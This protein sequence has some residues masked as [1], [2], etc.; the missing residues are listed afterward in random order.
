METV[1]LNQRPVPLKGA[2]T[3]CV[4]RHIFDYIIAA[5]LLIQCN[6]VWMTIASVRQQMSTA[7]PI[8]LF[9]C[10]VGRMALSMRRFSLAELKRDAILLGALCAYLAILYA[11]I[12]TNKNV[13]LSFACMFLLLL[14]YCL[15]C[16]RDGVSQILLK[17]RTLVCAVAAI[18]IVMWLLCSVFRLIPPSGV[19]M[20]SWND[21]SNSDTPIVSWFGLYFEAQSG[22]NTSIFTEGPMAALQYSLALLIETF[23]AKK[24]HPVLSGILVAA[25]CTTMT[26]TG[27]LV[28]LLVALTY[29]LRWLY[30]KGWLQKKA[31]KITIATVGSIG[32]V[33]VIVILIWKIDTLSGSIRFDD[34]R[35]G[36]LAFLDAPLFGNG[37]NNLPAIQHYMSEWR[38]FNMGYSSG[39]LWILSDGGLWLGAVY[40][41]PIVLATVKGI[42]SRHWGVVVFALCL[43]AIF[44]ITVFQYSYLLSFLTVFLL[45]WQPPFNATQKEPVRQE[46]SKQT[47]E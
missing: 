39:L 7:L 32:L 20:T 22:R 42:R 31:G 21:T 19:E 17:Y 45:L 33:T 3:A 30:R 36:W 47:S 8:V 23:L 38:H 2:K 4:F 11:V 26:T 29:I 16:Q 12:K 43:F 44:L 37:C 28:L 13:Y 18:S 15:I 14:V 27:F 10:V 25:L 40:L 34:L 24:P 1:S 5:V 41:C 9:V 35:A 6:T 46:L